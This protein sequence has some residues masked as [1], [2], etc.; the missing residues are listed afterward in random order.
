MVAIFTVAHCRTSSVTNIYPATNKQ[1]IAY[2]F[3]FLT[4]SSL[5]II[6][7]TARFSINP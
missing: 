6:I 1:F 7:F 5:A 2:I 4:P 3:V